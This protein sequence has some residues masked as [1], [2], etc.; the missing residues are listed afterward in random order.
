MKKIFTLIVALVATLS[1]NAVTVG[2]EDNSN[3]WW[4]VF[5]EAYTVNKGEKAVVSFTNYNK[6]TG[7]A[8]NWNNWLVVFTKAD[9]G[10]PVL[11]ANPEKPTDYA[12][13]GESPEYGVVRAD[14]W[15]WGAYFDKTN[16]EDPAT[17]KATYEQNYDWTDFPGLMNGAQVEITVQQDEEGHAVMEAVTTKDGK[18]YNYKVATKEALPA[19]AFSFFFSTEQAHLSDF[20]VTIEKPAVAS[21][22]T[23]DF[24][25]WSAETIAALKADAAAGT[26]SGWSDDEKNDGSNVTNGNCFWAATEA[27]A[28]GTLSANGVVIKEFGDLQFNSA[29]AGKRS[30]AIAVNYPETNLGTY[31]GPAYLWLGSKNLEY[32]TIPNVKAGST[33]TIGMESHKNTDARGIG[34]YAN[35]YE[36]ANLIGEKFTP[37]T[38]AE[39]TWTITSDCN[40]VVANTNG[41]HIYYIDIVA[42][43]E[44]AVSEVK[45]APAKAQ[46]KKVMTKN[47]IIIDGKYTIG[48][49]LIK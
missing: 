12:W 13:P 32:F 27:N 9:A 38:F 40:V 8:G 20:T 48:G 37:T 6:G 16:P 2:P 39:N 19:D 28:D 5:S 24:T 30:L 3:E 46:P 41:C 47:G 11:G 10:L 45:A 35:S 14:N 23:Y 36:D 26:D 43:S 15:G 21:N 1:A 34:L 22:H 33:I 49:A 18:S 44:T 17:W 42:G 4:Q 31:N 25:A 29:T 7:V